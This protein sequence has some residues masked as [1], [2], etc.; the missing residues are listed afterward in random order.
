M[1][2]LTTG[3]PPSNQADGDFG[4]DNAWGAL[5][6]PFL[7]TALSLPTPSSTVSDALG[8]GATTLELEATGLPDD[9]SASAIGL[10]LSAFV[11]APV[12][13]APFG[14]D[15]SRPVFASSVL[16]GATVASGARATFSDA[17]AVGGTFV[18]GSSSAPLVLRLPFQASL[19]LQIHDA[20]VTFARSDG[21]D[22]IVGTIAGVLDVDAFVASAFALGTVVYPPF[23]SSPT[24]FDSIAGQ[25]RE[26]RD[27]LDDG[28]N[29]SGVP[30]DAISIGLGFHAK[31]VANPSDV[32]V[33]PPVTPCE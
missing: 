8:K 2:T 17:Y 5:I 30:C 23:C 24:E 29:R 20:V 32:V 28:T 25:I 16:D 4:I 22:T 26:A 19:E 14:S 33:D 31:R 9:A 27:I 12:Q 15:V 7:E 13:T 11:A 6:L 21:D 1:C 10:R 3:A 18:S